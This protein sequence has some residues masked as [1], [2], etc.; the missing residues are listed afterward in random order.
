MQSGTLRGRQFQRAGGTE[1]WRVLASQGVAAWFAAPAT[2]AHGAGAALVRRIVELA[3]GRR[4]PDIDLRG[5]GVQVWIPDEPALTAADVELA[6]GISAAA[7]ELGLVADP[8]VPQSVELG[9]DTVDRS[10]VAPFWQTL[11]GYCD[12]DD[13]LDPMRRDPRFWFQTVPQHRP[14]R[15][16]I[17]VDVAV[18]SRLAIE[19]YDLLRPGPAASSPGGAAHG[20]VVDVDG[21]EADL[22]TLTADGD[23]LDGTHVDDWRVLFEA[24][25]FY[26]TAGLVEAAD[27]TADAAASADDAHVPLLID[28]RSAGVRIGSGKDLWEE[29]GFAATARRVQAA[30]RASGLTPDAE[31]LRFVQIGIDAVDIPAVRAFWRAVLQYEE[32]PRPF[33]TDLIDPRRLGP[34]LFF[35][36]MDAADG[37]RRAQRNRIHVDLFLPADQVRSRLDSALAAGGRIAYDGNAPQCW[38]VADPEGN[39]VDIA[40]A[41]SLD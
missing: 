25:V 38:T 8:T 36:P 41:I 15:N 33:V 19:R 12:D 39:E 3:A 35:Q 2:P 6:R 24:A 4:R 21:N 11:L 5:S 37:A 18:P 32:D 16:R 27:L 10:A 23:R 14:L 20:L 28:V 1:D 34:T 31:P 22:L 13:L 30:A 26:P 9:F 7:R 17:H 29:D 40:A